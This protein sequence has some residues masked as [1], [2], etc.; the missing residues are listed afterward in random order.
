MYAEVF[1]KNF[2]G[3]K[4]SITLIFLKDLKFSKTIMAKTSQ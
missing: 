1:K 3:I 2:A 4:D